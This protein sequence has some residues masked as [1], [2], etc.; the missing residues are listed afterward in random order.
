MS[1]IAAGWYKDPV[2]PSTQRYWD[3]EGWVGEALPAD[4]VPPPGPLAATQVLPPP[5]IPQ[6]RQAAPRD[7]TGSGTPQPGVPPAGAGPHPSGVRP[8]AGR[9]PPDV[10]AGYA[11]LPGAMTPGRYAGYPYPM[12]VPRPHGFAVASLGRRLSARLVDIAVVL[13]LNVIAN[14][15]L[16][17]LLIHDVT[18]YFSAYMAAWRAGERTP[19]LPEIPS[20][21]SALFYVIPLVAMA[22]WFA[23]EVPAIAHSGQTWGKRMLGVKVMAL[24]NTNPLGIRR[25]WR[26]WNPLGLPIIAY[27]CFGLGLVLQLI[28]CLS[29]TWGGPLRLSVQDRAAGTVVVRTP[30]TQDSASGSTAN[31]PDADR[32]GDH[33]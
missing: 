21:A 23:Y 25:S 24:E 14:G 5:S 10:P 15:Y 1:T 12:V 29:A 6:D 19:N 30:A 33:L 4:A 18:P 3:G 28:T 22:L 17:Y 27:Y 2:D 16:V 13:G 9:F 31:R 20:R 7:G 26:R 11:G 32:A 8:P